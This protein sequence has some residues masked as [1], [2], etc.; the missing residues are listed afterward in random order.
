MAAVSVKRS[1]AAVKAQNRGH[2]FWR[3]ERESDKKKG[4][5]RKAKKTNRQKKVDETGGM[6]TETDEILRWRLVRIVRK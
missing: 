1:I 4:G 6:D 2:E 5:G 3:K